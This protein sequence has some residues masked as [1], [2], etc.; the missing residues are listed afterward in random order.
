MDLLHVGC[1]FGLPSPWLSHAALRGLSIAFLVGLALG[2]GLLATLVL[3]LVLYSVRMGQLFGW[4]SLVRLDFWSKPLP[5]W[6]EAAWIVALP[7]CAAESVFLEHTRLTSPNPAQP[8]GALALGYSGSV[9]SLVLGLLFALEI[10]DLLRA[11]S[12]NSA[13]ARRGERPHPVPRRDPAIVTALLLSGICLASIAI[14][15]DFAPELPQPGQA[16]DAILLS[17]AMLLG[18]LG[19]VA[20]NRAWQRAGGDAAGHCAERSA[21]LP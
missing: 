2:E 14:A 9:L 15:T 18:S 21:S 1:A 13:L 7:L 8:S 19:I 17:L 3:T 20:K 10:A 5:L 6:R 12:A 16:P 11:W 4:I